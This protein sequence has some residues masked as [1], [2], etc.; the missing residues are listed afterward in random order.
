MDL[1]GQLQSALGSA[2]RIERPLGRGPIVT[3]KLEEIVA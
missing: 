3:G 1:P 2:Y